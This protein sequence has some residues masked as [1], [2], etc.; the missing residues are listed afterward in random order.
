M[1]LREHISPTGVIDTD[2]IL[3]AFQKMG[4]QID[5]TEAEKLLK[6]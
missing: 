6:R 4:V 2:E 5:K 3:D 1:Y